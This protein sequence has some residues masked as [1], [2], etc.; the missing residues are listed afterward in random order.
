MRL[1]YRYDDK[2]LLQEVTDAI[3]KHG[4]GVTLAQ[5]KAETGIS[6]KPF[7]RRWGNWTNVKRTAI[8]GLK[9]EGIEVSTASPTTPEDRIEREYGPDSA[10]ITTKS[11]HIQTLEDALDAADVNLEEWEVSRFK[12]NSWETTIG[13]KNTGTGEPETYTNFQVK[14]WLIPKIPQPLEVAIR[15]L[16]KEI[17]KFKPP[18]LKRK[19]PDTPFALELAMYDAHFGKLAWG[20][21]TGQGD[22]DLE[23]A[24]KWFKK[25]VEEN[26][27]YSAP[28]K[29]SKIFYILGQDLLHVENY[30]AETPLGG[31]KLDVD[32][33]L[34]KIYEVAKRSTLQALYMCRDVAPVEVLWIP[35]NHDIHASFYLSDVVKEHFRDDK[36][37]EVD[38]SAPWRKARLWGNLLVGYTHDAN[39]RQ[40]NVVNMLPQFWPEEWGKSK[41]REWHTGHKHKK[42]ETKYTPTLTVGGVLIRQ[43]PTLSTIDAWHYQHGFVDAVPGGE[44]FLWSKDNGVCAHFTAFVGNS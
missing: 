24:E 35:G 8:E 30:M 10:I 5:F 22:Y 34:P 32:S 23:I 21:E 3:K 6:E 4:E 28:Y 13:A 25:A 2:Q 14:V 41:F 18:K 44:S 42:N 20:K 12:V 39:I 36:W 27:N 40:A 33:R 38:N 19:I 11:L 31:N 26:M 16:I 29:I 17:P 7:R 37:V 9:Q 15:N 43:I 1:G